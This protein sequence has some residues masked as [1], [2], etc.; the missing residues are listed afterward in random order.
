M[1][2]D[3]VT[4]DFEVATKEAV[5]ALD[6]LTKS[7][8]ATLSTMD[9]ATPAASK[10]EKA[11]T[12][13][14]KAAGGLGKGFKDGLVKDFA[15]LNQNTLSN[16][17]VL[18]KFSG[19]LE[20]VSA[21][22][23]QAAVALGAV[24]AAAVATTAAMAA[25]FALGK[26][27]AAMQSTINAFGNIAS[28]AKTSTDVLQN[29]RTQ[30]RGT[31]S[32]LE[33]MRLTTLSLQ[34]TSKG[35]RDVVAPNIGSII[36][37]TNR[38]A[39]AT[40]QSAEVVRE[41]FFLGLRRQSKLL[42]DDVGVVVDKTSA[43]FKK[44]SAE[45]GDEAA[46]AQLA[47]QDLREVGS[48]LGGINTIQ[49]ALVKPFVFLQNTLDKLAIAIQPAFAPIAT[50]IGTV[51]T[52]LEY[53][54]TFVFP[55][56]E[57]GAKIVGAALSNGFRLA[58]MVLNTIFGPAI[59]GFMTVLPYMVVIAQWVADG[60]VGAMNGITN[61][62]VTVVGGIGNAISG[63]LAFVGISRDNLFGQT[64][65]TI[66]TLT[67]KLAHGGGQ[68]IGALARGMATAGTKVIEVAT[69]IAKAVADLLSGESPPPVGPLSTIDKGGENTIKAWADGLLK[70]F[71][72]PVE[73]IAASVNERLGAIANFGISQIASRL[74][75]LDVAIRPFREN[76]DIAKADFQAMAGYADPVLKALERQQQ[77]ALKGVAG[78]ATDAE[79]VR[80]IDRQI[81]QFQ[82]LKD[83]AESRADQAQIDLAVAEARQAQERA[84]LK[85]QQERLGGAQAASGGG[86]AKTAKSAMDAAK[87]GGGGG[88]GAAEDSGGGLPTGG[89]APNLLTNEAI[90]KARAQLKALGGA[91]KDS[92][93]EGFTSTGADEAIGDFNLARGGLDEQLNRIRSANPVETIKNKFDG[94]ETAFDTPI[95]GVKDKFDELT[96]GITEKLTSLTAE[97]GILSGT[98]LFAQSFTILENSVGS[99]KIAVLGKLIELKTG[100]T[101]QL[102]ALTAEGGILS[103]TGVFGLGL[104]SLFGEAGIFTLAFTNAQLAMTT[105]RDTTGTI[106]NEIASK[107]DAVFA[108]PDGTIQKIGVY[109]EDAVKIA[110]TALTNFAND[111]VGSALTNLGRGLATHL[112]QPFADA[113]N[114]ILDGIANAINSFIGSANKVLNILGKHIE[115]F[116]PP[117]FTFPVVGAATGA[118]GLK[119]TFMAGEAGPE[120]I[121][122][123]KPSTVFPAAATKALQQILAQPAPMMIPSGN[124]YNYDNSQR[125]TTYNINGV[126]NPA[127]EALR[128]RQAEAMLG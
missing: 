86:S 115:P 37:V 123:K 103:A 27:G 64:D 7:L 59:E 39:Q 121:T 35:F 73:Q 12:S 84:L 66:T 63:A 49:E 114:G 42:L 46:Y 111:G 61:A 55:V 31:V 127:N 125:N 74:A 44:L 112:G 53:L 105:F 98:G 102:T 47:I 96:K 97:G 109:L 90:E 45:I 106:L 20:G 100:V 18:G 56:I 75:Q 5:A 41:K 34:G 89:A 6:N 71:V 81:D 117:Q 91:A 28:G 93:V 8:K 19:V 120:L 128:L 36:D 108:S 4:L 10:A 80:Q 101:T 51:T 85:I 99:F 32:D 50:T 43:E 2:D 1:T 21:S 76:L 25:F 3:K 78:G 48:E 14:E 57:A 126:G 16:I 87:K 70:G 94:L 11:L 29:L 23:G 107:F 38:V 26:R 104:T 24:A 116:E 113:V 54:S 15:R 77:K 33:L 68:M 72:N 58:G 124:S 95:Q 110:E 92:F 22:G 88:A 30:T 60:V 79:S 52:K 69:Q 118:V 13:V 65:L 82:Q 40:G 17:P 9:K 119:G 67:T 122:T 62:I 83:L